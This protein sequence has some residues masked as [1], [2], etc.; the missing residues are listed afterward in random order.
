M[1][2]PSINYGIIMYGVLKMGFHIFFV[3]SGL[4]PVCVRTPKFI[5]YLL[6][7]YNYILYSNVLIIYQFQLFTAPLMD[8]QP[9]VGDLVVCKYSKDNNWYRAEICQREEDK[10]HILFIDYGNK[11]L[12]TQDNI[13]TLPAKYR[14]VSFSR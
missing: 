10:F 5:L 11:A 3:N 12:V 4:F 6:I 2:L 8:T 1:A 7:I 14:N 13:R 9:L